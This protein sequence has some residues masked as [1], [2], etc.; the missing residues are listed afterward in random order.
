MIF[1]SNQ[2][3]GESS[4]KYGRRSSSTISRYKSADTY[5]EDVIGSTSQ[6]ELERSWRGLNEF[7]RYHKG[8]LDSAND[9]KGIINYSSKLGKIDLNCDIFTLLIKG[10]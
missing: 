2:V 4:A 1:I 8:R 10:E 3:S 7:R 6:A 9:I 5:P